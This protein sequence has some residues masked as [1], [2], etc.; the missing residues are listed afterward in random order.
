MNMRIVYTAP[1]YHTNQHFV[2]KALIEAGHEVS[3][4]ALTRG[5][6][7]E[8]SAL[9]PTILGYS[10]AYDL[11][12]RFLGKLTG[13]DFVGIPPGGGIPAG[14]IPPIPR[15]LNEIRKL[16]PTV[17][18]VRDPSSTYGRLSILA[19]IATRARLILYSQDPIRDLTRNPPKTYRFL[20]RS[21]VSPGFAWMTPVSDLAATVSENAT[22]PSSNK[23]L[24]IPFIIEPQTA[25]TDKQWF[26]GDAVNILSIGKFQ[27]RKNH[28]LFLKVVARLSDR[29]RIRSTIIGECSTPD[30][31]KALSDIERY[32]ESLGIRDKLKIKTNLPFSEVQQ[33]YRKHDVFVLASSDEPAAV[34]PLE[35][36]SHS[37][38][39]I[40]SD[41]N[42]TMCYIRPGENGFVFRTDDADD[43]E[44]CLNK[45]LRN[46]KRLIQM[47]HRSHE[48]VVS[49]HSPERYVNMLVNLASP[50]R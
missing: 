6:S 1:R 48:L 20:D 8:Y 37:L 9:S 14:G 38:P 32:S 49:E 21:R 5:L 10:R 31:R 18:V 46:R 43:L 34:S 11:L 39:V 17:V 22:L 2:M 45:T 16:R 36:M 35:A 26:D 23:T 19:A 33:E 3:F 28:R 25:P 29:H 47:G 13:K 7:E 4:L 42:G 44:I 30:H 15:F 50:Q 40:C 24:Y 12:R 41:S 27:L